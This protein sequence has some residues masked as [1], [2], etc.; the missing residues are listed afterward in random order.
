MRGLARKVCLFSALGVLLIV[1]PAR[2]SVIDFNT[3]VPANTCQNSLTTG[4]LT[5]TASSGAGCLGVWIGNPNG[6]GTR[7]L[8]LGFTGFVS[9]TQGGSA[10]NLNSFDMGISW[11]ET[12]VN[13]TV[14]LTAYYFGGGTSV[15][16]LNLIQALQT[17][18]LNLTSLIQV[19]IS[20]M[21]TGGGYW[22]LDDLNV[23]ST[24]PEPASLLLLGTGLA[25]LAVRQRRRLTK[26]S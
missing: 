9:I 10:F 18:S 6:N 8:I 3:Y 24:V 14:T 12:A 2:A 20:A 15:Q 17:Y 13:S 5:F 16:T 11:Y 21:S 7:G 25:A 1:S 26:R 4:G 19:D 23:A 22:L